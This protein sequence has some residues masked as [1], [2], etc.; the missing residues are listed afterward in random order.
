M[1]VNRKVTSPVGRSAMATGF[2]T[3]T[4][5]C[6]VEHCALLAQ[7][8]NATGARQ[9]TSALP[10]ASVETMRLFSNPDFSWPTP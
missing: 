8:Y 6:L 7:R 10:R 2:H 3:I 9:T 5:A 1:S 4:R